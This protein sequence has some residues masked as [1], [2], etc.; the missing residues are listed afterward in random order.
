MSRTTIIACKKHFTHYVALKACPSNIAGGSFL[1]LQ[2]S[3]WWAGKTP[4]K[5]RHCFRSWLRLSI[6][7]PAWYSFLRRVGICGCDSW[8][9]LPSTKRLH[10]NFFPFFFLSSNTHKSRVVNLS[11]IFFV[12]VKY[13]ISYEYYET[14]EG[15]FWNAQVQWRILR[16][17]PTKGGLISFTPLPGKRLIIF[18]L[19]RNERHIKMGTPTLIMRWTRWKWSKNKTKRTTTR[20][21]ERK[22]G[23]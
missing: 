14:R 11:Q 2:Y 22:V 10:S 15:E 13:G 8:V 5:S 1:T 12:P 3:I 18:N 16:C 17:R 4:R 6:E 19:Q 7:R 20:K 9:S 21:L 23:R